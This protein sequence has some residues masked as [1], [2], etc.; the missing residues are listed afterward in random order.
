MATLSEGADEDVLE[1]ELD[2]AAEEM[3]EQEWLTRRRDA[4]VRK[5]PLIEKWVSEADEGRPAML[6][7]YEYSRRA[8]FKSSAMKRLITELSGGT[9]DDESVIVVRGIAKLFVAELVEL[10]SDIRDAADPRSA[11]T[12]AHLTDAL[13]QMPAKTSCGARKRSKFWR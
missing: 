8:S 7:R 10:A 2:R 6:E 3:E 4:E 12:P 11:I 13:N 5:L 1:V 9:V